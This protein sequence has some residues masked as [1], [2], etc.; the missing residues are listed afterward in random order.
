MFHEP[1]KGLSGGAPEMGLTSPA[2]IVGG[3]A[4]TIRGRSETGGPLKGETMAE[5]REGDWILTRTGIQFWPLD[6]RVEE[7]KIEDIAHALAMQ[8]RFSGHCAH[9]YSVAQHSVIVSANAPAE[10]ALWGLLHDAAEAYLVDLPRPIKR[11]SELGS[12]YKT[13]EARIMRCIA[14]KFNLGPEPDCLTL[15]DDRALMTEK[16]DIMPGSQKPWK[17]TAEPFPERIERLSPE[18][19]RGRFLYRFHSL[20]MDR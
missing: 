10:A 17:E 3:T 1:R 19:A 20:T 14:E 6:P 5:Q 13:L 11:Y 2:L 15:L 16:R 12:I 18:E 7:I 4:E 9:H 8:C